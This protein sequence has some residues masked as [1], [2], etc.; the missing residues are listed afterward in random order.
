MQLTLYHLFALL[1]LVAAPVKAIQPYQ[2]NVYSPS[3]EAAL[4]AKLPT[5]HETLTSGVI[6]ADNNANDTQWNF[7]GQLYISRD[8][9]RAALTA[10]AGPG[11][12]FKNV[13]AIDKYRLIDGNVAGTLYNLQGEQNAEFGAIPVVDG[14]HFK[15][16]FISTVTICL[17]PS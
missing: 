3:Y 17:M 14:N 5:F 6:P 7:D 11:G 13:G 10:V 4:R 9:W 8:S 1:L 15:Y 2:F 12:V 16:V